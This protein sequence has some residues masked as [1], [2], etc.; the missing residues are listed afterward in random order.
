MIMFWAR[1]ASCHSQSEHALVMI[2]AMEHWGRNVGQKCAA[3]G[4]VH[5]SDPFWA[6][7]ASGAHTVDSSLDNSCGAYLLA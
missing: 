2:S 7:S 6:L 4:F 3:C 1:V 5:C